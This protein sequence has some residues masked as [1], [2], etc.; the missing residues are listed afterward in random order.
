M[1]LRRLLGLFIIS[2]MLLAGTLQSKETNLKTE[3]FKDKKNGYFMFLPPQGWT[4]KHYPDPRT[5][6]K[7]SHP[8]VRNFYI[9]FIVREAPGETFNKMIANDRQLAGQLKRKGI[10][11]EVKEKDF[12]GL[13]CSEIIAKLPDKSIS[14]LLKFISG[15]IHFNIN[16]TA[17]GETQFDKHRDTIMNSLDTITILKVAGGDLKK[18]KEQQ[19]AGRIRLAELLAQNGDVKGAIQ[20]LKE[21]QKEFPE[22]KLI[23]DLLNKLEK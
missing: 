10:S 13:K 7:F 3:I 18:A 9:L 21:A 19:I 20:E 17:P 1:K 15:G 22:S 2:V 11:C 6:V 14:M 5:K 8:S 23:Q 16:Y 4:I 12:N